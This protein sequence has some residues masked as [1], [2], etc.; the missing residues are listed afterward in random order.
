MQA[1][2]FGGIQTL[3]A[4]AAFLVVI[5]HAIFC[6]YVWR[7][8][9]Y[10]DPPPVRL[11]AI[12]VTLFFAIS[13]FVIALNRRRPV[14]RF[15]V[16]RL[17]RIYPAYWIAAGLTL[18]LLAFSLQPAR[19]SIAAFFLW[20]TRHPVDLIIPYWTLIYE[21]MFYT[22]AVVLFLFRL[23][24]RALAFLACLWIGII[25]FSGYVPADATEFTFPAFR[26]LISP[27]TQVLPLGFICGVYFDKIMDRTSVG[28]L[29]GFIPVG[30]GIN[31]L[32]PE[33]SSL[34]FLALGISA[35]LVILAL[36]ARRVGSSVSLILGDASYGI[37]LM[38]FPL[39][40]LAAP[41][42]T[43]L[44]FVGAFAMFVCVG[45]IGGVGFGL[46]EYHLVYKRLV[47]VME[48]WRRP[49]PFAGANMK[50]EA[51]SK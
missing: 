14:G 37:Y 4:I 5:Q 40:L 45:A 15:A 6:A 21:M 34:R 41:Y 36:A 35:C 24:D 33:F 51:I 8:E 30:Y 7:G 1:R 20:P 16:H 43:N 19:I 12:G 28:W 23:G 32:L 18:C 10:P 3:R 11:G 47:A 27:I 42:A 26:L 22:I 38:H 44:T 50:G 29:L 17:L 9:I 25:N 31:L 48:G 13:G 39:M 46:L 49:F 2:Y